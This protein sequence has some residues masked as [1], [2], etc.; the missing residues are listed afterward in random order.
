MP[1]VLVYLSLNINCLL[2]QV[3]RRQN[4]F[5]RI[6][7]NKIATCMR[8]GSFVHGRDGGGLPVLE[9]LCIKCYGK[10]ASDVE[11]SNHGSN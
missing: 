8:C 6:A 7:Y 4:T 1:N 10:R 9:L 5:Q 2:C 11:R 3:A